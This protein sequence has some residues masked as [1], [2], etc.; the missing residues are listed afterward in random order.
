MN[1]IGMQNVKK[2]SNICAKAAKVFEKVTYILILF[3]I[4]G[5]GYL[6]LIRNDISKIPEIPNTGVLGKL[7]NLLLSY[8]GAKVTF[9]IVLI[10]AI[11]VCILNIMLMKRL[12]LIFKRIADTGK[13]NIL[14]NV[15][16]IKESVAIIIAF[17][18]LGNGVV[19]GL[20]Y[21]LCLWT[22]FLMYENSFHSERV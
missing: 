7:I 22:V 5:F 21:G 6:P 13:I 8:G 19:T 18:L 12:N 3:L 14:E 11:A 20:F 16:P 2:Y 17:L 15:K 9:V 10:L 1:T 4:I